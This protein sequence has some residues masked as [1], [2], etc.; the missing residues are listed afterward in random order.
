MDLYSY[1]KI[2]NTDKM[3][4]LILDFIGAIISLGAYIYLLYIVY[5]NLIGLTGTILY[6]LFFFILPIVAVIILN[7]SMNNEKSKHLI[8][9][10]IKIFTT[11]IGNIVFLYI[12][13]AY[14]PFSHKILYG[15]YFT[16]AI[17]DIITYIIK[18]EKV[19]RFINEIMGNVT[20]IILTYI[21]YSI[22]PLN[23]F[24]I[25]CLLLYFPKLINTQNKED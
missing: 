3:I 21:A 24:L 16:F 5:N 13:Q 4:Y 11:I 17:L 2:K 19:E 8:S 9:C 18:F 12:I 14:V 22:M 23:T 20:M 10:I 7:K 6:I 25:T 1:N 15:I